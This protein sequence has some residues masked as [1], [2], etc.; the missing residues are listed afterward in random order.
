MVW[1]GHV[2]IVRGDAAPGPG[3]GLFGVRLGGTALSPLVDELA[4]VVLAHRRCGRE[5]PE[6]LLMFADLFDPEYS[7]GPAASSL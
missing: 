4:L 7:N 5:Y 1:V 3:D 6:G 2:P